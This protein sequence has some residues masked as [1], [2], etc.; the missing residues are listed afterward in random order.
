G[1]RNS[2]A[3]RRLPGLRS[4]S[5]SRLFLRCR[6]PIGLT[7]HHAER[8][9]EELGNNMRDVVLLSTI[10]GLVLYALV[11]PWVGILGWTWISLMNP[12]RLSWYSANLPV[13]AAIGGATLLGIL[14]TKDKR[15]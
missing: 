6:T 15:H 12:H 1:M 13:A 7:S 4:S 8:A 10:G 2:S 9:S 11:H 3:G 5:S 14:C